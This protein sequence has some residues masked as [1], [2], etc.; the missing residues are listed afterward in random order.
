MLWTGPDAW[1]PGGVVVGVGVVAPEL[2]SFKC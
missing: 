2:A 1:D